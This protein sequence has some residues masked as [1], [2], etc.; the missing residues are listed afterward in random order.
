MLKRTI[1][2]VLLALLLVFALYMGG[3]VFAVLFIASLCLSI[4]EMFRAIA[5]AGHRPV[6]GP[7]WLCTLASVPLFLTL[8]NIDLVFPLATVACALVT[9]MVLF[10]SNPKLEDILMSMLP[11]FA[12]MLPG[13]CMLGIQRAAAQRVD[14]RSLELMLLIMCF[15]VPLVGDTLA[16][17]IGSRFGMRKLCPSVSPNKS[18]EGAVAGLVGSVLFALALCGVMNIFSPTVP[19]LWHF[20]LLGFFGGLAGQIGDLFASLIKRHCQVKDFGTIFPGHGGMMDRLDSVYWAT[21][22]MY[23]YLNWM[24]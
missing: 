18:L 14:D 5:Q 8:Q 17:F 7:I 3:W 13:L 22:V 24:V 15:A 16:Y 6:Q 23:I 4:Y 21:M 9:A 10:R 11:L 12:V 19:P 2:G 1:T 20:V